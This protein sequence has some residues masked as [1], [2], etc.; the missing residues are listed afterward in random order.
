MSVVT[1]MNLNGLTP[2]IERHRLADWIW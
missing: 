1:I 2:P